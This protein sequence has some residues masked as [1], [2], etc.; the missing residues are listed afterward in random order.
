MRRLGAALVVAL[1]ALPACGP[2]DPP[3]IEPKLSVLQE[4]VFDVSCTFS[5]CHSTASAQAGLVLVAPVHARL[6][7][8]STEVPGRALV[9]AGSPDASF[10]MDKLLGRDLPADPVGQSSSTIMPPGSMLEAERI[11]A[12]RAWI[13][14]GALDD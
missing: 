5:S 4:K 14:A 12:V 1:V 7:A 9:V 8:A 11:E 2:D 13:A 10:L 3:A 6:L